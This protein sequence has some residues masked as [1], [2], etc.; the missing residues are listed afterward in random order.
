[1]SAMA[2][3]F[4]Q[5]WCWAVLMIVIVMNSPRPSTAKKVNP[6]SDAFLR[7]SEY[8]FKT[9]SECKGKYD[10]FMYAELSGICQ[11]C[12]DKYREDEIY[13]DCRYIRIFSDIVPNRRENILSF[14]GQF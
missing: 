13:R 10:V 8:Q 6:G 3:M 1:M 12:A 9:I 5:R 11:D 2:S 14:F 4:F 7:H